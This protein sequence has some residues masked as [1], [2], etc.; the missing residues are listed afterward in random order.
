MSRTSDVPTERQM[1]TQTIDQPVTMVN[2]PRSRLPSFPPFDPDIEGTT[3]GSKW[4]K[5]KRRFEN[6]MIS[7]CENNQAVKRAQLLTYIREKTNNNF[8]NLPNTWGRFMILQY[9]LQ[10]TVVYQQKAKI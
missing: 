6:L 7:V 8:H 5:W 4:H 3:L 2:I 9:S 10:P 1:N